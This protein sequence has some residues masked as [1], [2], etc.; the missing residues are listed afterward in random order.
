MQKILIATVVGDIHATA[1]AVALERMGHGP[2]LWYASD[3]PVQAA[4]SIHLPATAAAV[5]G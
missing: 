1:V 3:V 2:L 4:A 5:V